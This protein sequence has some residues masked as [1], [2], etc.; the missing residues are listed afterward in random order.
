[1][2]TRTPSYAKFYKNHS[3]MV[4]NEE[5][6]SI[7]ILPVWNLSAETIETPDEMLRVADS[8]RF[9]NN[10]DGGFTYVF[11]MDIPA[12]VEASNLVKLRRSEA[13]K[14]MFDYDKGKGFDIMKVLPY[15]VAVCALIF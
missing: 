2:A 13:L 14:S 12:R 8:K 6:G 11:N 3:V 10:Q 5:Q 1:M 15:V 4:V 7:D 9:Y